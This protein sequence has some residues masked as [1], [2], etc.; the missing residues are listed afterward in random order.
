MADV[1]QRI[2][3]EAAEWFVTWRDT[4]EL[5]AQSLRGQQQEFNAW[6]RQS[7]EHVHEY[8][9]IS[10]LWG[11]VSELDMP[12]EVERARADA[13]VVA[14][15]EIAAFSSRPVTGESIE[16]DMVGDFQQRA[17]IRRRVRWPFYTVAASLLVVVSTL[18][19]W[20]SP[21]QV[22]ETRLGEQRTVTLEDGSVVKLN[23]L[24]GIKVWYERGARRVRLLRGEA[25]FAVK[26]DSQRPFI[27]DTNVA[28]GQAFVKV[29]GTTFNIYQKRRETAVTVLEGKVLV[30]P[31]D[32]NKHQLLQEPL[33]SAP[34]NREQGPD[35]GETVA[36]PGQV[37][38]HAGQQAVLTPS[39]TDPGTER[40]GSSSLDLHI[41]SS[42]DTSRI[43]AW[44]KRR[45]VFDGQSL[46]TIVDEFNRY[47]PRQL[48]VAT[49]ELASLQLS[50]VFD[51]NDPDSLILYIS[52]IRD[53]KVTA[54]ADGVRVIRAQ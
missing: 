36:D 48:E 42:V 35:R 41:I 50:G 53:I 24:S 10:R 47:N 7:G 2:I 30:A 20:P 17:S 3:E 6:L 15:G 31:G 39:E 45:L 26:P 19:L 51:S 18:L 25:L 33:P 37:Q 40:Q 23:T 38:L 4:E 43:V 1:K 12:A 44:T 32:Y 52:Q 46:A 8:L 5:S 49:P 29:L 28:T 11:D 22:H 16:T 21:A 14:S 34:H 54:R 13:G 9:M 27:V